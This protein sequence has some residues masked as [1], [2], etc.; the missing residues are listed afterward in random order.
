MRF[1]LAFV[2]A[3]LLPA[4]AN[5]A[6]ITFDLRN[7]AIELIDEVNSFSLTMDGLTATLTAQPPSFGGDALLLNQTAAAFGVNVD[8]TTC[9]GQEDSDELDNGCVG[10][11]ID[12]VFSVDVL[13]NSLQVSSFGAADLGTVTMGGPIYVIGATG[14]HNLGNVYLPAGTPMNVAYTAGNGFSF[15]RFTVTAIPEPASLLLFGSGLA[16]I[17][18][19]RRRKKEAN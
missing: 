8:N 18:V 7:P 6:P 1:L 9:G 4:L 15:D 17:A 2:V 10:E 12:V 11:S 13:L 5:A 14:L 19:R 16:G 3:L